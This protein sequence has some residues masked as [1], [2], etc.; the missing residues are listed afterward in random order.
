MNTD[1]DTVLA[2]FKM[3]KDSADYQTERTITVDKAVAAKANEVLLP[4]L[5]EQ[6]KTKT[7]SKGTGVSTS[8]TIDALN[9]LAKTG[10]YTD[11]L[12]DL[13][14]MY[15]KM[16]N[17]LSARRPAVGTP[18]AGIVPRNLEEEW[19]GGRNISGKRIRMHT[20]GHRKRMGRRTRRRGGVFGFGSKASA[21]PAPQSPQPPVIPDEVA[22]K[23]YADQIKD[24]TEKLE[25][26]KKAEEEAQEKLADATYLRED[27]WK[28]Y[29]AASSQTSSTPSFVD[30]RLIGWK[31]AKKAETAA[32]QA[33][34]EAINARMDIEKRLRTVKDAIDAS[35]VVLP[36]GAKTGKSVRDLFGGR[37]KTR[38][39]QATR[40]RA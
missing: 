24:L 39:R 36:P 23:I 17:A 15:Q 37:R 18:S 35:K 14:S 27:T 1:V 31:N 40:R 11:N 30:D 34:Q 10:T 4:A 29:R 19:D 13:G 28:E 32:N 3:Y 33:L 21:P 16:V 5:I 26:A 25:L 8:E 22:N 7:V 38:R 12:G 6:K 2:A 20:R 9:A